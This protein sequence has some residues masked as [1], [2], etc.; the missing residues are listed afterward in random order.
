[1]SA[2]FSRL[3][4]TLNNY[5][6]S[7]VELLRANA[8]SWRYIVWGYEI[9]PTTGTPH[10]QGYCAAPHP[11]TLEAHKRY[12]P[13]RVHVEIARAPESKNR[14]YCIKSGQF[15][16]HGRLAQPGFRSD[17]HE[18]VGSLLAAEDNPIQTVAELHPTVFVKYGR[19][20][21]DLAC[22]LRLGQKR[23]WRTKL[24]V[25]WGYPGTGKSFGSRQAAEELV[26]RDEIYDK[27]RGEWWDGYVDHKA[28]IIDDF[29]GWL[30]YDELLKIADRYPYRVPV[31][32]SFANFV[33]NY[34]FIT[35][36]SHP[37]DWY[38]FNGFNWNAL[39]RRIDVLIHLPDPSEIGSP[40][41]YTH[42][43]FQEEDIQIIKRIFGFVPE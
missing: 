15:E 40:R 36:N 21:R 39:R 34:I 6:D 41:S 23:D 24:I 20:L 26:G 22:T 7:D 37:R 42:F 43:E 3:A 16:E 5:S 4:W 9:A 33:A 27:T 13:D 8:V 31:K 2:R 12:L 17:L 19:G 14:E 1:M 10:L 28:V 30:K 25:V 32:G 35:S 18:A 38:H 29:Y 11:R